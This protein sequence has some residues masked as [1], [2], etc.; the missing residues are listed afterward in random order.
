MKT[1][2][3]KAAKVDCDTCTFPTHGEG[4][5]PAKGL[6]YFGCGK[7]GHFSGSK[8]CKKK[9]SSKDDDKKKKKVEKKKESKSRK[10]KESDE[11]SDT[12]T[13]SSYRVKDISPERT[14]VRSVKSKPQEEVSLT[15][16]ALDHDTESKK[17][18]VKLVV[19]TGVNRTLISEEA[20][21]KLKPHKGKRRPKL[22]KNK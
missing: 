10:V 2:K 15:M 21:L 4:A 18:E 3:K 1:K 19:D 11:D 12:D 6:E 8:A 17:A 22:M 13:E 9:K 16:K 5:C 7:T 20:W 14:T